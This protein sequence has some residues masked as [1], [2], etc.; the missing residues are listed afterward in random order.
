MPKLLRVDLDDGSAREEMIREDIARDY[1]GPKGVCSRYLL[2]EV[3]PTADPLSPANKMVFSCGP[4]SGSM[5]PGTNRFGV[6]FISPLTGGY[7]ESTSGGHL[8]TQFARTGYRMLIIE[9]RSPRPVFLEVSPAGATIHSAEDLWGS[10]V[11]VT[12]PALLA[13][14]GVK[15]A[16]ATVVGPAGENLVRFACMI[17]D[18]T[19]I[20]GR[21]GVGAVAGS[22]HLKGIVFHGSKE[23]ELV[24]P[25]AVKALAREMLDMSRDHPAAESFRRFGTLAV[26][27]MTNRLDLFPTR[28]WQ[29]GHLDGW[30]SAIGPDLMVERYKVRNTSCPPCV[31]HCGNL[32][33]VPEGPLKG[34]ELEP[35]FETVY[36]FAGLCQVGDLAEV[37]RLNEICDRLGI[38]T[39]SAG[40]LAGL[41]IEACAQGRLDLG[42]RYGDADGVAEFVTAMAKRDGDVADVFADGI[43][44][45][46][47]A[48]GLRDVAVHVKGMEPA[49]Y[50]PRRSK[51]MGLGYIMSERGAC[52]QRATFIRAELTGAIDLAQVEGK[53]ALYVDY[54]DRFVVMDCMIFC[55]FYRDLLPWEFLT[56]IA[57]AAVGHDYATDELRTIANRI[58]TCTHEINRR[59]GFG[60]EKESF[61][62]WITERSIVAADGE[63]LRTTAEE[64]ETMRREYYEARG[65]KEPPACEM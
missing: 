44:A 53:A 42:L 15:G 33:R 62:P 12:E 64:F 55:H 20:L 34:L 28:Y 40:N 8:A 51:G 32:C 48:Y 35:E 25:D 59:R 54:E 9:G 23:A 24:R 4:L 5:M 21:G 49:G 57:S 30:E 19:H 11:F 17:N 6:Y 43:L 39:I 26:V 63:E 50:D 47:K 1:L 56:R 18:R 31:L 65:W 22:K 13:R 29:E 7:G 2:E 46:E 45:A 60:P 38:D 27:A 14:V 58:V 37:M 61:G 10:D 16:R 52:H 3:P 36:A 41:A